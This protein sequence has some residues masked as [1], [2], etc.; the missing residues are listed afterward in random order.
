MIEYG[1]LQARSGWDDATPWIR[2]E[3]NIGP[4]MQD[5]IVA[6]WIVKLLAET[7]ELQRRD[8]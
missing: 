6:S 5:L 7:T 4:Q 3:L 2:F 1:N 8:H